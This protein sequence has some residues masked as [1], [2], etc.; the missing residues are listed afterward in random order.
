MAE[1]VKRAKAAAW[2]EAKHHDRHDHL[3]D[4][5]HETV[6]IRHLEI[7]VIDGR[8]PSQLDA[9]DNNEEQSGEKRGD[10]IADKRDKC[11]DLVKD[12]ILPNRR[13]HA[14]RNGNKNGH[15]I[16]K[17]DNPQGLR[18]P[19][20][21]QIDDRRST[22]APRDK[23]HRLVRIKNLDSGRLLQ[24]EQRF[25]NEKLPQPKCVLDRHRLVQPHCLTDHRADLRLD[26]LRQRAGGIAGRQFE[27]GK[28]DETDDN[29]GRNRH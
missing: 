23:T 4:L 22:A 2:K 13:Y 18:N 28:D 7:G 24:I 10:G 19:L 11:A 3:L 6:P 12:G 26:R 15:D 8:K 17:A 21:N 29:Q 20:H 25:S 16:G 9:K 27:H 5:G 14:D 1:R